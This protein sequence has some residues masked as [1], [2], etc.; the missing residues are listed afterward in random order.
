M[1]IESDP[2]YSSDTSFLDM[3]MITALGFIVLFILAFI[4]IK[5]EAK[6]TPE[7]TAEFIIQVSWADS[8][9]D[10][11]DTWVADP[12][13]HVV[14]FRRREDGLLHLTRDDLGLRND[15]IRL[16]DGTVIQSL[17]NREI[18]EIRG[19]VAGEYVVNVHMYSKLDPLPTEV[20]IELIKTKSPFGTLITKNVILNPREEKTAFRFT[21][22]HDGK[23]VDI[24]DLQKNL[25]YKELY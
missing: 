15:V 4:L 8:N 24:N 16:N 21:L 7:V 20:K 1:H 23:V 19:I 17:V 25:A 10:D 12:V 13:G 9:P 5:P 2:K 22:T 3:L 11:V 18:V 6:P 14:S